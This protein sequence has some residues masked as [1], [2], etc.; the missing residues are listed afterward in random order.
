[1][2]WPHQ[3]CLPRLG[4]GR[5]G[6]CALTLCICEPAKLPWLGLGHKPPIL[7]AGK[8]GAG[9]FWL[10]GLKILGRLWRRLRRVTSCP[11]F[12]CFTALGGDWEGQAPDHWPRHACPPQER[13]QRGLT[14]LEPGW[15]LA[16]PQERTW[17]AET[18][19][20]CNFE[21]FSA[22][23]DLARFNTHRIRNTVTADA[24]PR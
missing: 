23:A 2:R 19:C 21:R 22:C 1:M 5:P 6:R 16:L 11:Q 7:W 8:L 4:A 3:A 12:S 24:R 14:C 17:I 18:T 9:T 20:P 13:L 15:S 10:P